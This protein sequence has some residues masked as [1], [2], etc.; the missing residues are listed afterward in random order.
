[1]TEREYM[2]FYHLPR[3]LETARARL[4]KLEERARRFGAHDLLH[5][6]RQA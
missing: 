4:R 1:M 6:G 5:P 3:Q 2:Q